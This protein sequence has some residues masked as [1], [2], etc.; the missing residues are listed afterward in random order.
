VDVELLPPASLRVRRLILVNVKL[1]IGALAPIKL[2]VKVASLYSN[3][4]SEILHSLSTLLFVAISTCSA[5]TYISTNAT[6]TSDRVCS[7]CAPGY[8]CAGGVVAPQACGSANKYSKGNATACAD[9]DV[10]YYSTP[11]T[12]QTVSNRTGKQICP[13]GYR[14]SLGLRV[15]CTGQTF[16]NETGQ[17][18]C[19]TCST[20]SARFYTFSNCSQSSDTVCAPGTLIIYVFPNFFCTNTRR[21]FEHVQG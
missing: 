10:G 3:S 18:D 5:G 11:E 6:R 4:S 21:T 19:S 9:V 8:F 16:Q 15:A 20:C 7:S 1:I 2:I 12:D 13:V 17:V 14:C